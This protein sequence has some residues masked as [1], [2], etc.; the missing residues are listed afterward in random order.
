[1]GRQIRQKL[2][3]ATSER[4][5]KILIHPKWTP[6]DLA[7]FVFHFACACD[8]VTRVVWIMCGRSILYSRYSSSG[9][10]L[11]LSEI[12]EEFWYFDIESGTWFRHRLKSK[13]GWFPD[14]QHA[15][16][17]CR[18]TLHKDADRIECA[19]NLV[20]IADVSISI[21]VREISTFHEHRQT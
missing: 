19:L 3:T 7:T 12:F 9:G 4:S 21:S 16:A 18:A 14:R 10:R 1:M 5:L 2:E 15:A 17:L 8:I 13:G 6:L 20:F 11:W